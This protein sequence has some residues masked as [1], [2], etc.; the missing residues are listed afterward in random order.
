MDYLALLK[1]QAILAVLCA[2]QAYTLPYDRQYRDNYR[3]S[4]YKPSRFNYRPEFPPMPMVG[5]PFFY[6]PM[7]MFDPF[8]RTW[9]A[10]PVRF[11]FMRRRKQYRG[12]GYT[13]THAP[14]VVTRPK[15]KVTP[16]K[17]SVVSG[18][19]LNIVPHPKIN[20]TKARKKARLHAVAKA[21]SFPGIL[22][23]T[24]LEVKRV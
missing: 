23:N 22:K 8:N 3:T 21:K 1:Q 9:P 6:R 20:A 7:P 10:R 17:I 24:A 15:P 13:V 18:S 2:I 12:P 19:L 11:R 14:T 4:P 5:P 16:K